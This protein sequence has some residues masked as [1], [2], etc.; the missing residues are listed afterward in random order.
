MH[1]EDP[2]HSDPIGD[3]PHGEGRPDS[4]PPLTN[5]DSFERL[6]PLLLSFDDLDMD[7]Y[8]ITYFK[9]GKVCP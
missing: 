8:G 6:Y 7:L 5:H 9:I 3:L 4:P 2:L 1:W